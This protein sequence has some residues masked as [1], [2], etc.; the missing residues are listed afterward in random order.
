MEKGRKTVKGYTK[1]PPMTDALHLGESPICFSPW[2]YKQ[3]NL[4]E[5][6]F[7]KLKY[8]IRLR[9]YESTA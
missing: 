1:V 7:N 3:R 5:R 4:V 8:F 6:F 9:H 2:L